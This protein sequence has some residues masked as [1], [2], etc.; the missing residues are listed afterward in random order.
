M[1]HPPMKLRDPS[2]MRTA[3]DRRHLQA[4]GMQL[5]QEPH[6][7]IT[8]VFEIIST[9]NMPPFPHI[10]ACAIKGCWQ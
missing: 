6:G 10:E 3:P 8:V 7:I 9:L 2:Q 4:T 1:A 5:V